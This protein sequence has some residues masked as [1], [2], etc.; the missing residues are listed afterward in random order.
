MIRICDHNLDILPHELVPPVV[1]KIA[2]LL[3][4]HCKW[5]VHIALHRVEGCRAG[6]L[7]VL[8]TRARL[9]NPWCVSNKS[10]LVK[11]V[12]SSASR[13]ATV[14]RARHVEGEHVRSLTRCAPDLEL[15]A[16][17]V[18]QLGGYSKISAGI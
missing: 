10:C 13:C 1:P 3:A 2:L 4:R 11:R 14:R 16:D 9:P 7:P 8:K 17:V 12:G 5:L 15:Y 6:L 18:V